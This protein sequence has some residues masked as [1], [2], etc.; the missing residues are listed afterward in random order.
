MRKKKYNPLRG[1]QMQNRMLLTE[2]IGTGLAFKVAGNDTN[3]LNA[4]KIGTSLAGVPS[5]TYSAG[6]VL[7][8]LKMLEMK[9]KRKRYY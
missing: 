1:V 6:N 4:A 3:A 7:G 2:T 9:Q 5:L 8:S